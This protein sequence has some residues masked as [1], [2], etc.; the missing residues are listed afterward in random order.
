MSHENLMSLILL[1]F[2]SC[3]NEN[4]KV[5]KGQVEIFWL[6]TYFE[7][8]PALIFS[9]TQ[10]TKPCSKTIINLFQASGFFLYPPK[11]SE[12]QRFSGVF[13]E[14]RKGTLAWNRLKMLE[15]GECCTGSV[16]SNPPKNL[17]TLNAF[18]KAAYCFYLQLCISVC[19]YGMSRLYTD[20]GQKGTWLTLCSNAI[21]VL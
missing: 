5:W 15:Y 13:R 9:L 8:M 11:T 12:N 7:E 14:S 21:I 18:N 3:E 4:V 17:L 6:L 19:Y 2:V 16:Q 1:L 10:Q 20:S